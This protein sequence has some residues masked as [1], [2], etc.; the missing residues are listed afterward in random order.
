MF[1]TIIYEINFVLHNFIMF[2]FSQIPEKR[3]VAE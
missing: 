2:I 1:H 3:V